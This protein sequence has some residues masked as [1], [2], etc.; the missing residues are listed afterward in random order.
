M[1]GAQPLG[2]SE[3]AGKRHGR[4]A[5]FGQIAMQPGHRRARCAEHHR[6]RRVFQAYKVHHR[7]FN[8]MR[9]DQHGAIG[10]IAM[11]FTAA[12]HFKPER[13]ALI[14]F[15]ECGNGAR[16]SGRKH[17]RPAFGRHAIQDRCQFFPKA[18]VQHLIGFIQH[19]NAQRIGLQ[20]AAFQMITKPARGA[21]N[22]MRAG[23]KLT[24]FRNGIHAANARRNAPAGG[25]VQPGELRLHLQ[26]QFARRCD[27]DGK[28]R[29]GR[30]QAFRAAQ[31]FGCDGKTK[32]NRL[33]RP[34]LGRDKQIPPGR[35]FGQDS[36]LHRGGGSVATGSQC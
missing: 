35:A 29:T 13:I 18:E 33:A 15:R 28:R 36:A 30:W 19:H 26:G 21:N 17:Q 10:D 27:D 22:D 12:A 7:A 11:R 32:G 25:G 24:L 1:Q 8:F 16:H 6:Q 4:K 20:I 9:C 31:Q 3:L 34:G 5:A 23:Q 14:A 2:L